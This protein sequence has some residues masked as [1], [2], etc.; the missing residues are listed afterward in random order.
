M[1]IEVELSVPLQNANSQSDYSR[2]LRKAIQISNQLAQKNLQ[3]ARNRQSRNY[4]RGHR[5]W[6]SFEVGDTIWLRRPKKW[7][8]GRKWTGPYKIISRTGVNYSIRSSNGIS[9]IVH[10]NQLKSCPTPLNQ[11]ELCCP[12]PETPGITVVEG[13]SVELEDRVGIR[14]GTAR[15]PRLRQVINPPTRYGDVVAH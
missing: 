13:E 15:P 14:G 9:K 3:L 10:H 4:D 1:P 8:F 5:D 6:V 2:S 7:K 11:G 12:S